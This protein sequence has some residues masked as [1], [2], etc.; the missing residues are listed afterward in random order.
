MTPEQ[1]QQH[2][3]QSPLAAHLSKI[4]IT[5]AA[6]IQA[7]NPTL[8][9]QAQAWYNAATDQIILLSDRLTPNEATFVAWH[10]MGHRN[11]A[12][13]GWR[14]W[15]K[16]WAK[17]RQESTTLNQIA[18]HIQ[19]QRQTAQQPI[20]HTTATEEAA[21]ELYAAHKTKQYDTLERKY[22]VKLPT[23]ERRT[24]GGFFARLQQKLT[25]ITRRVLGKTAPTMADGQIYTLLKNMER[26]ENTTFR[27]PESA[28]KILADG[29]N[30]AVKFNLYEGDKTRFSRAVDGIY[31]GKFE[32]KHKRFVDM[33]I[34]PDVLQMLGF[35]NVRV[36]IRETT[37]EKAFRNQLRPNEHGHNIEPEMLKRLPEQINNPVAIMKASQDAENSNSF[38]VLTELTETEY[39]SDWDKERGTKPQEMPVLAALIM[40]QT[41]DGLEVINITSIHGRSHNRILGHFAESFKKDNLLYLNT[42]KGS[43]F[44]NVSASTT[45]PT[46]RPTVQRI[47]SGVN[48]NVN[49][50]TEADLAQWQN[51]QKQPETSPDNPDIHYSSRQPE[52]INPT[53]SNTMYTSDYDEVRRALYYLDPN[54]RD[55]WWKMGAALK[56]EL[57]ESGK[58]LWEDWSRQYP[59][60]KQSESNAQ[61][62]SFKHGHINIGTLFHLAQQH[63]FE[64]AKTYQAP[65]AEQIAEREA[66]WAVKREFQEAWDNVAK[67]HAAQIAN[68]V[69]TH[70]NTQPA[71]ASFPYLRD[72]GITDPAILA[73][74]RINHYKGKP[75]LIIPMYDQKDHIINRQA[76]DAQGGKFFLPNGEVSGA[77]GR[78]GDIT[79]ETLLNGV[80]LAEGFATAASIHIATGK[81]VIIAFNAGNLPKV[82]EKMAQT[83]PENTSIYIAADNDISQTGI[84]KATEA[85]QILG[86]RAQIV[87]PEFSQDDIARFQAKHGQD[88]FPSDFNDLHELHGLAVVQDALNQPLSRDRLP[89]IAVSNEAR[90]TPNEA[91]YFQRASIQLDPTEAQQL[92]ET[93]LAKINNGKIREAVKQELTARGV[94]FRQPEQAATAETKAIEPTQTQETQMA[95]QLTPEQIQQ[96]AQ[97][98]ANI[99]DSNQRDIVI[100]E[101]TERYHI[102]IKS[103]VNEILDVRQALLMQSYAQDNPYA[104]YAAYDDEAR[105]NADAW[106][107]REPLTAE[108]MAVINQKLEQ[109]GFSPTDVEPY[110][111]GVGAFVTQKEQDNRLTTIYGE[112]KNHGGASVYESAYDYTVENRENDEIEQ[113]FHTNDLDEAIEVANKWLNK[114]QE[115]TQQEEMSQT[116]PTQAIGQPENTL[117]MEQQLK[118]ELESAD[119]P[120]N[121]YFE[122]ETL[123]NGRAIA[124][125]KIPDYDNEIMLDKLEQGGYIATF[126]DF[127]LEFN[128]LPSSAFRE[129]TARLEREYRESQTMQQTTEILSA[130]AAEPA[131]VVVSSEPTE[132]TTEI[133]PENSIE[134]DGEM[135]ELAQETTQ[136]LETIGYDEVQQNLAAWREKERLEASQA[137]EL[138]Q[139]GEPQ[140]EQDTFNQ[141]QT[142]SQPEVKTVPSQEN[143][144][145]E[146]NQSSRLSNIATGAAAIGATVKEAVHNISER[147][148]TH[149]DKRE[150]KRKTQPIVDLDY[151]T[152]AGLEARYVRVKDKYLDLQNHKTVLFVD[153]GN[154]LKTSKSDPQI[155]QDMLNTAQAKN[156]TRIKIS[157]SKEFKQQMWLEAELRGIASTGYRP[158]KDDIALR[159][160]LLAERQRNSIEQTSSKQQQDKTAEKVAEKAIVDDKSAYLRDQADDLQMRADTPAEKIAANKSTERVSQ[161]I[162]KTQSIA[163]PQ[164]EQANPDN[165]NTVQNIKQQLA[166][167]KAAY[168]SMTAKLTQPLKN[169]LDRKERFFRQNIADLPQQHRDR[170]E[171]AYYEGS[172]QKIRD[173]QIDKSQDK[174][175]GDDLSHER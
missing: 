22:Q 84:K 162:D 4:R 169:D 116:E 19:Q 14:D 71:D 168:H 112:F 104:P 147:Y 27:Q 73:T 157:G 167:A 117:F 127:H 5:T 40:N 139:Q 102:N 55:T 57:D 149:L 62:K 120:N 47:R 92:Y 64:H 79:R 132:P 96:H 87:M 119:L 115:I 113:Y 86:E 44:L 131:A 78:I 32:A 145:A 143:S 121:M 83:L 173:Y 23:A 124:R 58:A 155:I 11:L 129:M 150:E 21:A 97:D 25:H 146:A 142:P 94:A 50:K 81:P 151:A 18:T 85:A 128:Q 95:Q 99:G 141:Q 164:V 91:T 66:V 136:Q 98:I 122:T 3:S 54:D 106:Q 82:A 68:L 35:P 152:A 65:T 53:R 75:Q 111:A 80:Y 24:L 67:Q 13:S 33:G 1:L 59:H 135:Q 101:F 77:Y 20:S 37:I 26:A 174:A 41:H 118:A 89:E 72:K 60:W 8:H 76:I 61:W 29:K 163:K 114:Q 93:E 15:Q 12:V 69:W 51:E 156:W 10:E 46:L 103:H 170:L 134:F 110:Q 42:E 159:D 49:C 165:P 153:K 2:L 36:T 56:S 39:M 17:A 154:A 125:I 109:S 6:D 144:I 137:Q 70:A 28:S 105:K 43:Q 123:S 45:P 171:L 74:V 133:E 34:T 90:E 140:F 108:K 48:L 130:T 158:S 7:T 138:W 166:Q 31:S 88:S 38:L 63:G 9:P 172:T 148:Q 52:H 175:K 160:A 100:D 161:V 16:A 30:A 107:Q 126:N